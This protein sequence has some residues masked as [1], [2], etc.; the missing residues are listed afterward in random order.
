VRDD[1]LAPLLRRLHAL[2]VD[3][4]SNPFHELGGPLRSAKFDAAVDAALAA[5]TPPHAAAA[6]QR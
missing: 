5:V 3:A 6:A 4:A 2:Y 1:A